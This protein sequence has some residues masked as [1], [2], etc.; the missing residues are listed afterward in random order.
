MRLC[1]MVEFLDSFRLVIAVVLREQ[2]A[3]MATL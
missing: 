2:R 1:T 3:P